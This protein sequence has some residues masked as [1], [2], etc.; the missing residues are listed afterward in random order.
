MHRVARTLIAATAL[1]NAACHEFSSIESKLVGDLSMPRGNVSD[2]GVTDTT[3]GFDI[4]SF[5][6][7]HTF[8]QTAHPV[9][10]PPAHVLSGSW[11]VEGDQVVMKFTWAHPTMQEMVGQELRLV[12]SDLQRN[13]FLSANAQNQ[14]QRFVWTRVK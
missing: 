8:S 12:I 1:A 11:R 6:A 9:E 14:N 7:D 5:K 4:T 3:Y 13:K 2:D 10:A